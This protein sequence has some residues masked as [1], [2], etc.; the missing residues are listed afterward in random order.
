LLCKSAYRSQ[1]ALTNAHGFSFDF[2]YASTEYPEW[3]GY[4]YNDAFY[5]ILQAASTNGG[6]TTNIAF[7]QSPAHEEICV[8][9]AFFEDPPE[10]NLEGTNFGW[11]PFISEHIGGSTGWYR[12]EWPIEPNETFF[13]TFSIHDESDGIFDSLVII[14]N[15]R[16]LFSTPLGMT[17]QL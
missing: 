13:L 5:A 3:V 2:L 4:S 17:H 10:T 12:T 14:D 1:W 6:A 11:D 7:D 8:N 15:F 16:W 9:S